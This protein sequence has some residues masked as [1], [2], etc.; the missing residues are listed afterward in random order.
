[1]NKAFM[2]YVLGST[3]GRRNTIGDAVRLAKNQLIMAGPGEEYDHTANKLQYTLL[4]DPALT[5][6]SPTLTAVVDSINGQ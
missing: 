6:A 2:K 1:M 5:L 3:D 4:G